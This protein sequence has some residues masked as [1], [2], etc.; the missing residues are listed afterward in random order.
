LAA[1]LPIWTR[2]HAAV[3]APLGAGEADRLRAGLSALA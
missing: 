2:T 1:A 3:E